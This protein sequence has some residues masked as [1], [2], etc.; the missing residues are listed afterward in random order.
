[1]STP[2]GMFAS[3][4]QLDRGTMN[5]TGVANAHHYD[6][7]LRAQGSATWTTLMF[8]LP[9]TSQQKTDWHH[10]LPMSGKFVL[11]VQ[12]IVALY[13]HG[14]QRNRLLL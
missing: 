5:W 14:L 2:T 9:T 7:R 11:H 4:I 6:I 10:Q 13:R 1:M 12:Q 3:N 8:N